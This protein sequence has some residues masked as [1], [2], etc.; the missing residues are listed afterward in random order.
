M[1]S[2]FVVW[3]G[4]GARTTGFWGPVLRAGPSHVSGLH[5]LVSEVELRHHGCSLGQGDGSGQGVPAK[6]QTFS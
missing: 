3:W 2:G 1:V 6:G 4:W 5:C